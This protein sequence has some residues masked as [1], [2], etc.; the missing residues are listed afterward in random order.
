[1]TDIYLSLGTNLG[2][3]EKNL[4][5][6]VGLIQDRIGKVI[7]LSSFYKT[8]PWGFRSDNTF[9]NAAA[10]VVTDLTPMD[11]LNITQ[12]IERE[13]GRTHKSSGRVYADRIIDIDLLMADDLIIRTPLLTLP[14]PLMT[15]RDFVMLPLAEI[16]GHLIHPTL[17]AS[18]ESLAKRFR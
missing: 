5:T 12:E 18:I 16:A 2:D 11:I 13:M 3:K 4:L 8:A 6:A 1:M 9:L 10:Y 14:H 7:S 17:N 15:E